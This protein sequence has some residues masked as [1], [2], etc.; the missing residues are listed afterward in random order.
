MGITLNTIF[1]VVEAVYGYAS[2]STALIAD[3]GHN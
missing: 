3:A 2:N 1:I